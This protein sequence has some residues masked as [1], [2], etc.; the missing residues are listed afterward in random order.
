MLIYTK[1]NILRK[2]LRK[3]GEKQKKVGDL[4]FLIT[5]HK[6]GGTSKWASQNI[7]NFLENYNIF[8]FHSFKNT[9]FLKKLEK[10]NST[11]EVIF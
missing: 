5:C 8:K 6:R 10:K 11:K 4:C 1:K 7:T 9:L 3:V 2:L